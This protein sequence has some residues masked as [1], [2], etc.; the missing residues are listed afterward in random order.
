MSFLY[1]WPQNGG[2]SVNHP[3]KCTHGLEDKLSKTCPLKMTEDAILRYI[4]FQLEQINAIR[5]RVAVAALEN[6]VFINGQ[7]NI[8]AGAR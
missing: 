8:E 5:F 6:S 4:T 2:D 3:L 7:A 1:L